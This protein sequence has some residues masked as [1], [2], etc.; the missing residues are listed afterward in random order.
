[1]Q[2]MYCI[3]NGTCSLNCKRRQRSPGNDYHGNDITMLPI[4]SPR[5]YHIHATHYRGYRGFSSVRITVSLSIP[6]DDLLALVLRTKT[7]GDLADENLHNC[8]AYDGQA[9]PTRQ[10]Q[11]AD[12]TLDAQQLAGG[13]PSMQQ[14]FGCYA[15]TM[16]A[17]RAHYVKT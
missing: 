4:P 14:R 6:N 16:T 11:T 12:F 3:S 13:N 10:L 1:M 17:Y 8:R 9:S 5:Y 7:R 2:K 15:C